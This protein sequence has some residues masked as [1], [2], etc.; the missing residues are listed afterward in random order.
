MN[1]SLT[2]TARGRRKLNSATACPRR[3]FADH[4]TERPRRWLTGRSVAMLR[5]LHRLGMGHR[6][7][8]LVCWSVSAH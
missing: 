6:H 7:G 5:S 2:D 4:G 3:Q 8:T 1:A